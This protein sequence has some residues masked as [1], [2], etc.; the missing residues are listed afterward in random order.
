MP[1]GE[2]ALPDVASEDV[3]N[4]APGHERVVHHGDLVP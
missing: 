2:S 4:A 1:A 3:G